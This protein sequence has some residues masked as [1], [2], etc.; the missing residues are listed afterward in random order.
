MKLNLNIFDLYLRTALVLGFVEHVY[1]M[2]GKWGGVVTGKKK[3]DAAWNASETLTNKHSYH[4]CPGC[5]WAVK[6]EDEHLVPGSWCC[7][8]VAADEREDRLNRERGEANFL[9]NPFDDP[10]VAAANR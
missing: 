3:C 2:T 1:D 7:D 4:S 10:L 6:E 8:A 5:K 9:A